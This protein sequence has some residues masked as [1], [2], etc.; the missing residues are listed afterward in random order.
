[1]ALCDLGGPCR[2]PA[3]VFPLGLGPSAKPLTKPTPSGG[4][5]SKPNSKHSLCPS[6]SL[7]RGLFPPL[8]QV[9]SAHP[10]GSA[11]PFAGFFLSLP[12]ASPGLLQIALCSLLSHPTQ[13]F[14]TGVF[15]GPLSAVCSHSAAGLPSSDANPAQLGWRGASGTGLAVP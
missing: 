15:H 14:L 3:L 11:L 8:I 12:S 7:L 5:N 2:G 4:D 13:A 10:L 9:F 1:M 6:L